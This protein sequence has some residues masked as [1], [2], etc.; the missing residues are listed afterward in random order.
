ML[1]GYRFLRFR[2]GLT[3]EED[4]TST[5]PGGVVAI[6]T[7][8]DVWDSFSTGNDFNGA[9][10]GIAYQ[11]DG[12]SWSWDILAKLAVGNMRQVVDVDGF[13]PRCGSRGMPVTNEGGLLALSTNIGRASH[14]KFAMIPELNLNVQYQLTERLDLSM[15]YSLLWVTNV[16]RSGDQIDF[17]VNPSQLPGNGGNLNGSARPAARFEDTSMWVQGIHAGVVYE[18]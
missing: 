11:R 3:I 7:T 12:G 8:F 9:E 5:D 17:A 1:A 10:L 18:F 6:G 16:A 2:E 14:N 15:G 4:L 13:T